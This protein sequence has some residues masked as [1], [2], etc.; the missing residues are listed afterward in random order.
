QEER[1][2][3]VEKEVSDSREKTSN[4]WSGAEEVH[5]E[6]KLRKEFATTAFWNAHIV[7]DKDG[8]TRL[9]VQLPDNLT[10]WRMT[11]RAVTDG[12]L[13]CEKRSK[14]ETQKD[15]L[16]RI[17]HPRFLRLGD[18]VKLGLLAHNRSAKDLVMRLSFNASGLSGEKLSSEQTV[19]SGTSEALLADYRAQKVTEAKLVAK[20]TSKV[21]SD[22]LELKLPVLPRGIRKTSSISGV[23]KSGSVEKRLKLPDGAD[24][25]TARLKISVNPSIHSAV[26][27][28]LKYLVEY[29][30]GCVEQTMSRFLPAVVAEKAFQRFGV[31]MV[32]LEEKLPKVLDAGLKRL[33]GFQHTDGGWGWWESD[34][35][36]PAMTAYVVLGL[37]LA[38]KA[39]VKVD[40]AVFEKGVDALKKMAESGSLEYTTQAYAVYALAEAGVDVSKLVD[41]VFDDKRMAEA[42]PYTK[43]LIALSLLSAQRKEDAIS[44]VGELEKSAKKEGNFSYWGEGKTAQWSFDAVETT[45]F[46][47]LALTKVKGH[48][49]I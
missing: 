41:T 45:A 35:T 37:A 5:K 48:G 4:K 10:E 42:N 38:R 19:S 14:T 12:T 49:D 44:V 22:A 43:A 33:Y 16:V 40:N 29:P 47:V 17:V 1:L 21:E 23:L 3:D 2:E 20:A 31:K 13:V 36:N 25:W 30:Y 39:D 32:S 9:S 27:E 26:V 34:A 46:C 7:T 15:V 8:K 28:A 6:A 24:I 18:R 11:T